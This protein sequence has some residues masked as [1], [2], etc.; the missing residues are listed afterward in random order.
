[1]KNIYTGGTW[2]GKHPF[3][4]GADLGPSIPIA[5]IT[6]AKLKW[7]WLIRFCKSVPSS[8][9]PID[10]NNGLV[11]TKGIGEVPIVQ[12]ANFSLWKNFEAI[13]EFAYNSKQ[14]KVAIRNSKK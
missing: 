1:M 12:M 7:N 3:I 9:E 4:K 13:K 10:G 8:R 5:V 14:H 11:F 2:A 6:R